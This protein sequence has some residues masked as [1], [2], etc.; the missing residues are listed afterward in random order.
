MTEVTGTHLFVGF[1]EVCLVKD[2][3]NIHCRRW[4]S[5]SSQ[6][7]LLSL[8]CCFL[9]SLGHLNYFIVNMLINENEAEAESRQDLLT[10]ELIDLL[11][12]SESGI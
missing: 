12:G 4:W 6:N 1:T 9:G 7:G 3:W 5:W 8:R 11:G 10:E 2:R